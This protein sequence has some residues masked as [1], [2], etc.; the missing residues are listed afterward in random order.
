MIYMYTKAFEQSYNTVCVTKLLSTLD[1]DTNMK[2]ATSIE[3]KI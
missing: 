2:Y 3:V 1:N